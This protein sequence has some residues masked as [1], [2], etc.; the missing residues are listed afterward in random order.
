M[1]HA[2]FKDLTHYMHTWK[3]GIFRLA[4]YI[5]SL[6]VLNYFHLEYWCTVWFCCIQL[7]SIKYCNLTLSSL[8]VY[9]FFLLTLPTSFCFRSSLLSFLSHFSLLRAYTP[10]FLLSIVCSRT[11]S[12]H[13]I[14]YLLWP[15]TVAH[16]AQLLCFIFILKDSTF[17][18]YCSSC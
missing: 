13:L 9:L 7:H 17:S 4:C 5:F 16:I 11:I 12:E 8:S 6:F 1:P 15:F 14:I 2:V 18:F 10:I 3:K